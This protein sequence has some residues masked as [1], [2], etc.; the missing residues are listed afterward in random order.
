MG[1]F[2]ISSRMAG[3]GQD[4]VLALLIDTERVA[5]KIM[6]NKQEI[7]ELDKRRQSN[8]E[9]L[10]EL[11]KATDKS[12]WTSVGCMIVKLPKDRAIQMLDDG[13]SI[14]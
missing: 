12:T 5:D 3:K 2:Q 4:K 7:L 9:A 14:V 6:V 8:R 1:L 10:N 13:M 11:K